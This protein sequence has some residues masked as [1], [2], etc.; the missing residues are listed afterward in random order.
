MA[1]GNIASN[2]NGKLYAGDSSNSPIGMLDERTY[3]QVGNPNLLDNSDFTNPVN[4]RGAGSYG[5]AGI[6]SIDR[7]KLWGG[8]NV[9]SHTLTFQSANAVS[10]AGLNACLLMQREAGIS[11]GEMLTLSASVNSTVYKKAITITGGETAYNMGAFYFICGYNSDSA[12]FEI[13]ITSG[14]ISIEWIKVEKGKVT[15]P[16]VA[17]DYSVEIVSCLRCYWKSAMPVNIYKTTAGDYF[18]N[19]VYFPVPMRIT[20]TV[21]ILNKTGNASV[22]RIT[23][24]SVKFDGKGGNDVVDAFE[25]S[26]D[27]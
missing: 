8:Y 17:K 11:V 15:T 27:F 2:K 14:S 23:V 6:Y 19:T 4:Q 9:D 22:N 26:A 24:D 18:R 16:Y 5:G 12:F 21:N 25:V 3:N 10:V 7:W 20:P 13:A 1:Y